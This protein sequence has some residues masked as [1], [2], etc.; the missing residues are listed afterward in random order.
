MINCRQFEQNAGRTADRLPVLPP[1]KHFAAIKKES[2]ITE[3]SIF[4]NIEYY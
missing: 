4:N 3:V 2:I 1:L